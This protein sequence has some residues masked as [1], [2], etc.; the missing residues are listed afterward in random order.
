MLTAAENRTL[1]ETGPGTAMGE[2]FRHYW[3][4]ALLSRELEPD[5]A[6]QR[7]R[8]LGEDFVAFRDSNGRVGIVDPRCTHRGANLFFGRN[9][10]AGLR[11]AYHG[12]KFDATGA[13]VDI[14][15][16]PQDV[17]ARTKPKAALRALHVEE[18][19]DV[20]WVHFGDVPPP[21]PRFEFA[22][23]PPEHRFVSKKFQQCNWA[24]AVEG[25]LDTAHFSYLHANINDGDKAPLVASGHNEPPAVARY[26]WLI[27]DG[28]P[29][30]TVLRHDAGLLLCAAR[31]ADDDQLY[32]RATQFMLPNHSLVPNSFPG[33]LNQGNTW[34]PVDDVSCWIFC[35]AY[36]VDRPMTDDERK[37]LA[38][39][40]GIFAA[41]DDDYVPI[42]NRDNDYLIDRN[43]QKHSSFTGIVG[44]SEQDAAIADSQGLIADRTRELLGQTDVGIV[45]FRQVMLQAAKDVGAARRPCGVD[46]PSAY[47]LR[48]GD[49]MSPRDVD[50]IALARERFG[51]R[52]GHN[53]R[54]F[55]PG[56]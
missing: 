14:P 25:G 40:S 49:I 51:R 37:R 36:H 41:V 19:G 10:Q 47:D 35:Y 4:P 22:E 56:G 52:A 42:R 11:C 8:L 38:A 32:W 5:G 54:T 33:D 6:P 21:L 30:F 50:P 24:Q 53:L 20:V 9:E 16:S 18:Y 17:A 28:M 31:H 12:W 13:C 45:R 44:V 27:E 46:V 2:V 39:G 34:V 55:Q 43:R 7:V 48:S 29:R 23:L 1:T 3:M 15:T 26:R